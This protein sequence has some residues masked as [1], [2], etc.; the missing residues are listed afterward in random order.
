[1]TVDEQEAYYILIN[2]F[3]KEAIDYFSA[4]SLIDDDTLTYPC[5][6]AHTRTKLYNKITSLRKNML[7]Y[8]TRG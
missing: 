2:N 1:M 6:M 7:Y 5:N 8:G 3:S 4:Q